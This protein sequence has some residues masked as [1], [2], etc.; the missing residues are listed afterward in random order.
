MGAAKAVDRRRPPG[1]PGRPC[2]HRRSN[3]HPPPCRHWR[4]WGP[5][6]RRP[7]DPR[8][9]AQLVIGRR[10][11]DGS[12]AH[13]YGRSGGADGGGIEGAVD[14][15]SPRGRA[16]ARGR[17]GQAHDLTL[18]ARPETSRPTRRAVGR[19]SKGPGKGVPAGGPRYGPDMTGRSTCGDGECLRT[20]AR[21]RLPGTESHARAEWMALGVGVGHLPL[22]AHP[23]P[24]PP[25]TRPVPGCGGG[26]REGSAQA[27]GRPA[28]APPQA[29]APAPA[30]CR[31]E[32]GRRLGRGE[33]PAD[34]GARPGPR[35]LGLRGGDARPTQGARAWA[36]GLSARVESEGVG[37]P[38]AGRGRK[39]ARDGTRK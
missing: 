24:A 16:G 29:E 5:P 35:P 19:G 28:P 11:A 39:E 8:L 1:P 32:E 9:R 2:P 27:H 12:I 21:T 10:R 37:E 3:P 4:G 6:R 17:P 26:R 36:R 20:Q 38:E 13:S 25:P 18:R 34:D 33:R 22:R 14:S 23:A 30:A 15:G 31:A 7:D